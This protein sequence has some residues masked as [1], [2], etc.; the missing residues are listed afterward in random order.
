MTGLVL[1]LGLTTGAGCYEAGR[2]SDGTTGDSSRGRL[3]SEIVG[4]IASVDPRR[5]EIE[6]R[7]DDRRVRAVR[8]DRRTRVVYRD[9][10]YEVSNLEPGDYVA[11]QTRQENY[12]AIY[13]D[14]V[15]V[16]QSVQERGD[17]AG[18]KARNERLD[19]TVGFV[20][21]QRGFFELRDPSGKKIMVSLPYNPARSE[22]D[23]FRSLRAGDRVRVEGRF[24]NQE[25]FELEAFL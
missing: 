10:E 13:A 21:S 22:V 3:E 25:R 18:S 17:V 23:R 20:D 5:Q 7:T 11:V 19:G 15:R 14:L 12:G 16:R 4:E 24:L 1:F 2:I 9:R 6:V 8:Y